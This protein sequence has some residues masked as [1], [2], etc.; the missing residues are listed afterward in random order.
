MQSG[1][2]MDRRLVALFAVACGI[3]AANLY[4]AQPLLDRMGHDLDS[5]PRS[6]GL[7]VT[8]AQI[9]YAIGLLFIVPLGDVMQRHKLIPPLLGICVV[10]LLGAACAPGIA[11][12]WAM[13]VLIG[14]TSVVA[15]ILVPLAGMLAGDHERGAVVGTVMSGLL[16]GILSGRIVSGLLA[17]AFGW[18]W[19]YATAAAVVAVLALVLHRM[20]PREVPVVTGL[21]YRRLLGSLWP[22]FRSEPALRRRM[23]YGALGMSSFSV[24]WTSLAFLIASPA[25]GYGQAVTGLLGLAGVVGA[26]AARGAGRLADKGHVHLA[27][28]FFQLCIGVGW[29]LLWGGGHAMVEV[30]VGLVVLDLGMQ[31]MHVSSQSII[32]ALR[33]DAR[34]RVTTLYLSVNFV[35]GALASAASAAAWNAGGWDEVCALGGVFAGAG[36][37]VWAQEHFAVSRARRL[38]AGAETC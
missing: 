19:V 23:L 4:Y 22:L 15:Q 14:V 10:G 21:T 3:C 26:T 27:T 32:Y 2:G 18:R 36:V 37:L 8:S 29:L 13:C 35:I 16:L 5:A 30:I 28:G 24:V 20:L 33:P 9:G 17:A 11:V 1:A 7:V 12:L 25:Y 6:I 31:G 34:S 38:D